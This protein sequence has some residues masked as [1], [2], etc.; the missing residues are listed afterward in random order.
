MRFRRKE[1]C[2]D[3]TSQIGSRSGLPDFASTEWV[4]EQDRRLDKLSNW[5]ELIRTDPG[6]QCSR[7]LTSLGFESKLLI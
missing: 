1:S 3:R 5:F 2:T 6:Q 7:W 4:A